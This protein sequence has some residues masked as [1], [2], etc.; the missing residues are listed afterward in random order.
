MA[1]IYLTTFSKAFSWMKMYKFWF[2]WSLF[3]RVQLRNILHWFRWWLGAD[4]ATHHYLTQCWYVVMMHIYTTQPQ[5]VRVLHFVQPWWSARQST[6]WKTN[7]IAKLIGPTW[8]PSGAVRTQVGPMF[9]PWTLLSGKANLR[10]LI[11]ATGLVISNWIQTSVAVRYKKS[12]SII[13]TV[14]SIDYRYID[15][16]ASYFSDRSRGISGGR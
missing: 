8:G 3:P 16:L 5:W 10:D 15:F 2:E 1:A 9:A 13:E 11:A 4:Q 12:I 7:Q 14:I 6:Q